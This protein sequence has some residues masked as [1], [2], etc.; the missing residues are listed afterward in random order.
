MTRDE[1][2]DIILARCGNKGSNVFLRAQTIKEMAVKQETVLE[3]AD[4]R[5]WFLLSEYLHANTGVLEPRMPLPPLF[6]E[7]Y[8]EGL[9]WIKPIGATKYDKMSHDDLD[10]L[11]EYYV[12]YVAGQPKQYAIVRQYAVL[13]P[14]PN[15]AYPLK[16]RCYLKEP[17]LTY[18][19]A[20]PGPTDP[21]T[22]QWLTNAADWLIGETGQIIAGQYLRDPERAAMF[23]KEAI[24]ARASLYVAHVAREEMN[25]TR[26]QGDE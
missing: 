24:K 4:F 11:E 20:T 17:T 8:E 12:D 3:R 5:P 9:L 6:L 13:F 23:E 18:P 16:M 1:A 22:N 21:I 19:Y 15:A 14:T 7:E 2:V 10:T 25:R 26:S